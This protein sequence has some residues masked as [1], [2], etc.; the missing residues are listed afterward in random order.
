MTNNTKTPE[1]LTLDDLAKRWEVSRRTL[2][3]WRKTGRPMP[4]HC[5]WM[6]M[7][8]VR[9]LLSDVEKFEQENR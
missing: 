1:T 5:R 6:G 4:Q 2:D 8:P 9:F 7:R 3:H